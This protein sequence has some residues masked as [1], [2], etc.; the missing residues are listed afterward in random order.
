MDEEK[1]ISEVSEQEP[2]TCDFKEDE[3]ADGKDKHSIY[4]YF[5]D[6]PSVLIAA[7]SALVAVLTVA[8]NY[9]NFVNINAYLS[10]FEIEYTGAVTTPQIRYFFAIA[11]GFLV[12][13]VISQSFI[14]R[15]FEAYTPYKRRF[16]LC[17][18]AKRSAKKKIKEVQRIYKEYKTQTESYSKAEQDEIEHNCQDAQE[19][20]EKLTYHYK[21]MKKRRKMYQLLIGISCFITWLLMFL[22]SLLMFAVVIPQITQAMLF[23]ALASLLYTGVAATVNWGL[24]CVIQ[25]KRKQ[26]KQDVEKDESEQVLSYD[27]FPTI[28]IT[29]AV[30]FDIRKALT[31]TTWKLAMITTVAVLLSSTFM[32]STLGT[33]T[34]ETKNAFFIITREDVDYAVIYTDGDTAILEKATIQDD[35]ITIDTSDQM[36]I[37]LSGVPMKKQVFEEVNLIPLKKSIKK[38]E[39]VTDPATTQNAET[40]KTTSTTISTQ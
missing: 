26:I 21:K 33:K 18:Y 4:N 38:E 1:K 15:T 29:T 40:D 5:K 36:M 13:L 20:F 9:I 34:A 30:N 11:A 10:F 31:N 32:S 39:T 27:E 37:S 3:S 12:V 2:G 24:Y 17:K 23:A 6:H 19:A 16:L 22:V 14:S 25:I 7:V 8:L 35:Q 28:P